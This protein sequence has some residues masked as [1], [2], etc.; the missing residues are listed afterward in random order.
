[1]HL[2][3]LAE[4]TKQ[5]K[6]NI[7][8]WLKQDGTFKPASTNNKLMTFNPADKLGKFDIDNDAVK[9]WMKLER[10]VLNPDWL[11]EHPRHYLLQLIEESRKKIKEVK[12]GG[13]VKIIPN[14]KSL[15]THQ[16]VE[17]NEGKDV[18]TNYIEAVDQ[19]KPTRRKTS[20]YHPLDKIVDR[21]KSK[22][23]SYCMKLMG[24]ITYFAHKW[25]DKWYLKKYKKCQHEYLCEC[26]KKLL[27]DRKLDRPFI[28]TPIRDP[29]LVDS[30]LVKPNATD[31]EILI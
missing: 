10:E 1:M 6:E 4:M 21:H 7:V 18:I 25:V 20:D 26:Q 27:A 16:C 5:R 3:K 8:F 15:L 2:Y 28:E 24:Y 22:G 19:M 12:S 11:Q 17:T 9:N 31:E 29:Q 23:S 14:E 13:Q 30:E